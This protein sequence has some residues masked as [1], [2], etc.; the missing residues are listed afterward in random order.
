MLGLLFPVTSAVFSLTFA[1]QVY[2]G[3]LV[4]AAVAVASVMLSF[5]DSRYWERTLR[6]AVLTLLITFTGY[7]VSDLVN[8]TE[9]P[10][11]LRGWGRMFFLLTDVIGLNA[12][13]RKRPM[14]IL[15]FLVGLAV[16]FL[17]SADRLGWNR[18]YY[19]TDIALPVLIIALCVVP[20]I[21]LRNR[22]LLTSLVWIGL[23]VFSMVLDY[24]SLGALC[25]VGGSIM[26]AK[27]LTGVR[28]RSLNAALVGL[29]VTFAAGAVVYSLTA[30]S[31]SNAERRMGSDS[32]RIAMATAAAYGIRNSP[33]VG[34]GSW[35]TSSETS[36]V[37]RATFAEANG[38]RMG[39]GLATPGHSQVLQVWYEAGVLGPVFFFF[40]LIASVKTLR[41]YLGS[42]PMHPLYAITLFFII[43]TIYNFFV[44][45]FGGFERFFLASTVSLIMIHRRQRLAR[46]E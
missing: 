25:M 11:L 44:S 37:I 28:L 34:S 45:H 33:L 22:Y 16:G 10:N 14:R 46:T 19:K 4:M 2:L 36:D 31:A 30:T 8:H 17:L 21:R 3:E 5:R 7:I 13:C 27:S 32:E 38:K 29:A 6:V 39:R 26:L 23:G 24:R 43:F 20:L 18:F 40:I 35:A 42:V 1:G 12:I 9:T 41:A 15:P